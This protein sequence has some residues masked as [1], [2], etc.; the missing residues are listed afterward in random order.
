MKREYQGQN[1]IYKTDGIEPKRGYHHTIT[2]WDYTKK[3]GDKDGL[4]RNQCRDGY[5]YIFNEE[6]KKG[7]KSERWF[8][9][10]CG[11][12]VFKAHGQS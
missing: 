9:E 3:Y 12:V 11:R 5:G 7:L 4:R 8:I 6:G 10:I 2:L 1:R